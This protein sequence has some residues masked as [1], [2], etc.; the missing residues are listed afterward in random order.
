MIISHEKKFIFVHIPKTGGTSISHCLKRYASYNVSG[1]YRLKGKKIL[2]PSLKKHAQ[3]SQIKK[4]VSKKVWDSYFKFALVRNPW[5]LFVS[6]YFWLKPRS[7]ILKKK[8]FKQFLVDFYKDLESAKLMGGGQTPFIYEG[9]RCLVD[10]VGS[11]EDYDNSIKIIEKRIGVPIETPHIFK[12]N[13]KHYSA[14]YNS[15]TKRI[16]AEVCSKDIKNFGYSF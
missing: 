6:L 1:E 15:K 14:Y 7:E 12:T 8:L 10:F 2:H 5:D 4:Y 11:F 13:H 9:G 16:V 3:A